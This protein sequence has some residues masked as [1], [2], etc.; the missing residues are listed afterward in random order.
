MPPM[1]RLGDIV[2]NAKEGMFDEDKNRMERGIYAASTWTT[3][4]YSRSVVRPHSE[5]A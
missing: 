3:P 1:S 5:A 2:E 4:V